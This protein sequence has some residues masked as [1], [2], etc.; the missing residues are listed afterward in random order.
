MSDETLRNEADTPPSQAFATANPANEHE[1]VSFE[2]YKDKAVLPEEGLENAVKRLATMK[3]LDYVQV[4]KATAKQYDIPAGMLDDMIREVQQETENAKDDMFP[5][6]EPWGESV[7]GSRLLNEIDRTIRR[8]I[9]CEPE[10]AQAASLWIVMTWLMDVVKV[11]PLAV[12]TAPEKRC[13]KTQLL[14]LIGKMS[15]RPMPTSSIT[16]SA[17]FRSIEM[18]QPTLLI[19]E[20]DAFLNDNEEMRGLLNAGHTRTSSFTIRTVGDDHTPKRFNVWGAK[21]IAGIGKLQDTVM[22][23]SV[24][25][26][27]RRKL[28]CEHVERIRHAEPGLFET[29]CRK[30]CRFAEDNRETIRNARPALPEELN[31]RAQDNWEPL[32]AIADMAGGNWPEIARMAA[33][34]ISRDKSPQ[35]TGTE[36]LEDIREIFDMKHIDRIHT[37]KLVEALC[38]DSEKPWSTYNR[39][40]PITPAQLSRRLSAYRIVSKAIR[41][42]C[43]VKRGF[44]KKQFADAWE[45]YTNISPI[46]PSESVTTLQTSIGAG[47]GVTFSKR[48]VS[49][50]VTRY[51]EEDDVTL[52]K[53]NRYKNETLKPSAGA[54]CNVLRF[55]TG[56]DGKNFP[57]DEDEIGTVLI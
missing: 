28:D 7:N 46:P 35:S 16:P 43:E 21:A 40:K 10:T 49:Q 29:L 26:E 23:R 32:L 22:D 1:P 34:K 42:D 27:L 45:R 20:A 57:H 39:G 25:L 2:Q 11:A 37:H 15:Y 14:D 50:N 56:E 48:N 51:T 24:T 31:D 44:E 12:I 5:E 53:R 41:V 52:S 4:R 13:G 47:S 3:K 55:E 38:E 6:I 8:F 30:L 33:L 18:W 17:L 19:D 36:L 9:V 54:G